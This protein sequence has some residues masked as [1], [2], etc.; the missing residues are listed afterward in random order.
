M[1]RSMTAGCIASSSLP[2]QRGQPWRSRD[3]RARSRSPLRVLPGAGHLFLL[4]EP[5]S[6]I[7]DIRAFLDA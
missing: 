5:E 7:G 3:G 1:P 6:V 2:W 4:D